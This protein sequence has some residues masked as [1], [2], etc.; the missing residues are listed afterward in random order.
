MGPPA[1]PFE[2]NSDQLDGGADVDR[3]EG[4][5]GA[6]T[7]I[8]GTGDD[9]L[10]GGVGADHF[11][12]GSGVDT[13]SY[14]TATAGVVVNVTTMTQGVLGVSMRTAVPQLDSG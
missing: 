1:P 3:L 12:G 6:D 14:E 8:G 2:R 13:V 4:G 9:T 5:D 7:L 11:L 10:I